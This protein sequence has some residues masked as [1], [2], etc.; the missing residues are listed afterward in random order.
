[1]MAKNLAIV[2]D[3]L[4]AIALP[5][6]GMAA[7]QQGEKV[8]R[9]AFQCPGEIEDG[10]GEVALPGVK[11]AAQVGCLIVL[12]SQGDCPGQVVERSLVS[13]PFRGSGGASAIS[14]GVRR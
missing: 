8:I 6:V 4:G 10:W 12:G 7:M 13:L 2:A 3:G 14:S 1:M 9:I 5:A 11:D